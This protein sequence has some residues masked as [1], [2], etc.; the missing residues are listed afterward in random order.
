VRGR[1]RG[2]SRPSA[3]VCNRP[4]LGPSVGSQ[5]RRMPGKVAEPTRADPKQ[6]SLPQ[7]IQGAGVSGS[8]AE[9]RTPGDMPGRLFRVQLVATLTTARGIQPALPSPIR[10]CP[11]CFLVGA[12]AHDDAPLHDPHAPA[13]D[14]PDREVREDQSELPARATAELFLMIQ[15]SNSATWASDQGVHSMSR[16]GRT[17]HRPHLTPGQ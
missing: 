3:G 2:R 4:R 14:E 6:A 7:G 17:I 9:Q 11:A 12:P 15:S 13:D 5:K 16:S 10:N 8:I 1:R